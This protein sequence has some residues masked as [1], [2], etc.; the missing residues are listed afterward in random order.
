VWRVSPL[1]GNETAIDISDVR[2]FR[3][4]DP[5][6]IAEPPGSRSFAGARSRRTG[7][8]FEVVFDADGRI[9]SHGFREEP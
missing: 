9:I 1:E 7:F 3:E 2:F 6:A 4:G 8:T 5:I